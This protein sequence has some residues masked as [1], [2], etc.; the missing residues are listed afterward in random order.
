MM[1]TG[2]R[3]QADFGGMAFHVL[4]ATLVV[5]CVDGNTV[6]ASLVD[7]ENGLMLEKGVFARISRDGTS[8]F[9]GII[10]RLDRDAGRVRLMAW[11]AS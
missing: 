7:K 5:E 11:P 4:C 9:S 10:E 6:V 8:V 1:K 3:L 2:E